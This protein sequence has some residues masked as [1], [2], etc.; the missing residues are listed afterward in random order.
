MPTPPEATPS[1]PADGPDT[2]TPEDLAVLKSPRRRRWAWALALLALVSGVGG[3]LWS[4]R[5]APANAGYETELVRRGDFTQRV[6]AVGKLAPLQHVELGSDLGGKVIE[7]RVKENDRVKA[8][9]VLARL[10]PEPF[11][12]AVTQARA[13]VASAQASLQKAKLDKEHAEGDL[14]RVSQLI[15]AGAAATGELDDAR[16]AL[17]AAKSAIHMANAALDQARSVLERAQQDLENADIRSPIDGVVLHRLVDPGQTVV[18]AM[19]ATAL[20]DVASDLSALELEVSVDEADIGHVKVG[21][22]ASFTVTTWPDKV[23]EASVISIDPA[24]DEQASVVVYGT[25]LLVT[26][27]EGELRPGMTATA[28]IEV[29]DAQDVL[30]VSTRALRFRPIDVDGP[31]G[32][33]LWTLEGEQPVAVPVTVVAS[34]GLDVEIRGEGLTEGMSVLVGSRR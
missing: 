8:G 14:A 15:A 16:Y 18:S 7:V 32:P 30:L 22:K 21:Q 24:A 34:N 25:H 2:P 9:E 17:D 4:T 1:Q 27:P 12:S 28:Q 10:D 3:F 20:F 6:T 13:S 19:S 29:G 26:N 31:D 33:A 11:E 23:F 5:K